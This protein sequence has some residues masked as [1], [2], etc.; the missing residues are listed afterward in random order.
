MVKKRVKKGVKSFYKRV[1]AGSKKAK[2]IIAT[3]KKVLVVM[4]LLLVLLII[5]NAKRI[6]FNFLI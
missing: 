1:R 2:L 4:I 6:S 5:L 3:Q